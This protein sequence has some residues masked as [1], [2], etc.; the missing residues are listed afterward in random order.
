MTLGENQNHLRF[1]SSHVGL[2][3]IL[4]HFRGSIWPRTISTA[5]TYG[6]QVLVYSKE[7]ALARFKAANLL[8]CRINAYL[9]IQ[10]LVESTDKRH[11]LSS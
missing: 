11:I 4:S 5:A 7:E 3:F 6:A 2:D 1:E 10:G 9:I 8:D